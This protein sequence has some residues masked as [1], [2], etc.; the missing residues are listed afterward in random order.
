MQGQTTTTTTTLMP[1]G[2][3]APH[4]DPPGPT[5]DGALPPALD[6]LTTS[7]SRPTPHRDPPGPIPPSPS[8]PTTSTLRPTPPGRPG[9]PGRGEPGRRPP[10]PP[11]TPKPTTTQAPFKIDPPRGKKLLFQGRIQDWPRDIS[12]NV[13]EGWVCCCKLC[14]EAFWA[15]SFTLKK[16]KFGPK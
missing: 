1:P 7:T 9:E 2:R 12:R 6:P 4:F 13:H 11:V 10:L 14:V 15:Q 5:G 8:T 3:P 16:C